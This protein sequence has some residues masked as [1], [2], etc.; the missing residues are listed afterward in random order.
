MFEV[1][2]VNWQSAKISPVNFHWQNIIKHQYI[3]VNGYAP[4][5]DTCKE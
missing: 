3:L 2:V 4:T 1:F 5:F